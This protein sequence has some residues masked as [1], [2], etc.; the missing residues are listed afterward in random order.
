MPREWA[1]NLEDGYHF[2]HYLLNVVFTDEL[3]VNDQSE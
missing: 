3:H 1:A 2:F